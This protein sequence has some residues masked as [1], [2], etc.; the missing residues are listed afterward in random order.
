MKSITQNLRNIPVLGWGIGHWMLLLALA[1]VIYVYMN[2]D[3]MLTL[4]GALLI[5]IFALMVRAASTFIT[6]VGS[7]GT[8]ATFRRDKEKFQ[9]AFN[10]MT[11]FQ[12]ILIC[13][14]EVWLWVIVCA[15]IA[16]ATLLLININVLPA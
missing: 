1:L 8:T 16:A 2:G 10:A 14:I 13:K 4:R 3:L 9:E 15:M 6:N 11:P 7:R 12:R 5:P